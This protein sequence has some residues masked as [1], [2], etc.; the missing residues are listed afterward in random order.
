MKETSE[1]TLGFEGSETITV[2]VPWNVNLLASPVV[3][4][5]EELKKE[6]ERRVAQLNDRIAET[7]EEMAKRL[8]REDL[9]KKFPL[10]QDYI[11]KRINKITFITSDGKLETYY[12][13]D[14]F[15]VDSL[16]YPHYSSY[17][18]GLLD[19]N[20][21]GFFQYSYYG[22]VTKKDYVGYVELEVEVEE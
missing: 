22:M 5:Y 10:P 14:I 18:N 13:D 21:K 2:H 20:E 7:R 3:D 16:G 6:F 1:K 19:W 15:Y 11:D 9:Y 12:E 4:S 8:L 17:E